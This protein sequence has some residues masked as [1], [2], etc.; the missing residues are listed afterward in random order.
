[1]CSADSTDNARALLSCTA[2]AVWAPQSAPSVCPG[3]DAHWPRLTW[4]SCQPDPRECPV[5]LVT[6]ETAAYCLYWKRNM[7]DSR[8]LKSFSDFPTPFQTDC[9][10]RSQAQRMFTVWSLTYAR[11]NVFFSHLLCTSLELQEPGKIHRI[12][13]LQNNLL[14]KRPLKSPSPTLDWPPP[15]QLNNST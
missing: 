9:I 15:C 6:H 3:R 12:E 1:M 13:K 10:S 8:P 7:S 11:L 2:C 14:W 4:Q 5:T